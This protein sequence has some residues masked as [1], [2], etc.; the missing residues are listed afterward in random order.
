M[1]KIIAAITMAC[2][3]LCYYNVDAAKTKKKTLNSTTQVAQKNQTSTSNPTK[4]NKKKKNKTS[5]AKQEILPSEISDSEDDDGYNADTDYETAEEDFDDEIP[6]DHKKKQKKV[7]KELKK[8]T[9]KQT[10]ADEET[11]S[12]AEDILEKGLKEQIEEIVGTPEDEEEEADA[13]AKVSEILNVP[14]EFLV[15]PQT[16][17]GAKGKKMRK[18]HL[19]NPQNSQIPNRSLLVVFKEFE[20]K[21][22]DILPVYVIPANIKDSAKIKAKKQAYYKKSGEIYNLKK[23][24]KIDSYYEMPTEEEILENCEKYE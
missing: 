10:Y 13:I 9:D 24:Q 16:T 2:L 11:S 4:Q 19:I 8:K 23:N 18:I 20:Q 17:Y 5:S 22:K 7:M 14:T 12:E 15:I 6:A 21:L 3:A 1:K